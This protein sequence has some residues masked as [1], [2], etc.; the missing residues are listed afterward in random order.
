MA[1]ITTAIAMSAGIFFVIGSDLVVIIRLLELS[2]TFT[3]EGRF[4]LWGLA[5]DSVG[6]NYITGIGP[7]NYSDFILPSWGHI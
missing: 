7:N 1:S 2:E 6:V 4:V 3:T 5:I